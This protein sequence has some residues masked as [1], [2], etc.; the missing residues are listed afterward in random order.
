MRRGFASAAV[1]PLF[2]NSVCLSDRDSWGTQKC[3]ISEGAAG[4]RVL[5]R[6]RHRCSGVGSGGL[7]MHSILDSLHRDHKNFARLLDFLSEQLALIQSEGLPDMELLLDIVGYIESYPDLVHHPTEDTIFTHFLTKHDG[8][9]AAI[10]E[11]L[12][13]EHRQLR[14]LTA[15]LR[16]TLDGILHDTPLQRESLAQQ[17]NEFIDRQWKHLNAEES[18]VFPLLD[19]TLSEED[20]R[21]IAAHLP[22]LAD[23]LFGEDL[24]Q[25][26]RS[27]YERV[28]SG[29]DSLHT[30]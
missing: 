14:E 5:D 9:D 20:W 2:E 19:R 24:Q 22:E 28:R 13:D 15:A 29:A 12:M 3:A 1:L 7:M 11:Y 23:P 26:F 25:Q 17:L 6:A 16:S 8:A 10:V 30:A 27:L 4:E 21:A 18:A